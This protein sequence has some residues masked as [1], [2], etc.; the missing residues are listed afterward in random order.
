[1]LRLLTQLYNHA[2]VEYLPAYLP[3]AAEVADPALYARNVR[4]HMS[5]ASG[6]PM[7]PAPMQYKW[8]LHRRIYKR[9]LHW[10]WFMN[11]GLPPPEEQE[12][13]PETA[14]PS[15]TTSTT[16]NNSNAAISVDVSASG[17]VVTF[18][19]EDVDAGDN[20]QSGHQEGGGGVGPGAGAGAGAG[21]IVT[22]PASA[23]TEI[24]PRSALT[25]GELTPRS[26]GAAA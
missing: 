14:G 12:L 11:N 25:G 15:G 24:T 10:K 16:A 23:T 19:D 13:Q 21:A 8:E 3:N 1:M 4:A 17:R 2:T 18:G 26:Y 9:Q 20:G 5:A 7:L 22:T 6:L